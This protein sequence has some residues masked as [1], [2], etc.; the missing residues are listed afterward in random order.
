MSTNNYHTTWTLRTMT[1]GLRDAEE[2]AHISPGKN[3]G[4]NFQ[5]GLKV[6]A[7]A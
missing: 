2:G 6:I 3:G 4:E 7:T 5:L 1:N